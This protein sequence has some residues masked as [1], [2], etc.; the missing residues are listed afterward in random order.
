MLMPETVD[1]PALNI[2]RSNY[3][4]P[5]MPPRRQFIFDP[6]QGSIVPR[7][8]RVP[9]HVFGYSLRDS[10]D[11]YG[12]TRIAFHVLAFPT[13]P[14][15]TRDPHGQATSNHS[16]TIEK[17]HTNRY[18]L[19]TRFPPYRHLRRL[20]RRRNPVTANE[21]LTGGEDFKSALERLM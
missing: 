3:S 15:F 12:E 7:I 14:N 10:P 5:K 8:L 17:K 16:G 13:S 4:S 11:L 1:S 18:I 21:R 19:S 6:V 9:Q 2:R 20:R